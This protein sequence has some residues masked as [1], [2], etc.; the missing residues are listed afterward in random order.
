[1][2]EWKGADEFNNS[3]RADA[4]PSLPDD[5]RDELRRREEDD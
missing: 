3:E 5:T 4:F 1:M 2:A